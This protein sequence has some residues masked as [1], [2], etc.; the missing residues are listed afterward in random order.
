MIAFRTVRRARKTGLGN[1]LNKNMANVMLGNEWLKKSVVVIE[2]NEYRKMIC[3]LKKFTKMMTKIKNLSQLNAT[4][5]NAK[6]K[7]M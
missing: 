7:V 2:D 5:Q 1:R 3:E 4:P 6:R